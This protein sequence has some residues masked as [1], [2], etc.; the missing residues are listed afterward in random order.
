MRI[1]SS[2]LPISLSCFLIIVG[3]A[4]LHYSVEKVPERKNVMLT[5]VVVTVI[6]KLKQVMKIVMQKGPQVSFFLHTF[7]S[8]AMTYPAL[9]VLRS[10]AI[11]SYRGVL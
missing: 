1:V 10:G 11:I 4:Y 5:R 6:K 3:R 8:H 9:H 2:F 7:F